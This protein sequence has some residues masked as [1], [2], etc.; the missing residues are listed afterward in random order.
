MIPT[1]EGVM[2]A[3]KNDWILRGVVGEFYPCK[4]EFF[5]ATYELAD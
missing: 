1:R 5:S 2:R 4:P 3:D